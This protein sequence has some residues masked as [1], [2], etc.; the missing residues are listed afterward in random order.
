[1]KSILEEIVA[2]KRDEVEQLKVQLPLPQ[3]KDQ[4]SVPGK[5]L[6]SAALADDSEVKII[7]ELKKASPS[8]GVLVQD[9]NP[10]LLARQYRD[11][12]ASALSVLTEEK[13]FFGRPEYLALARRESELPVM[14]KDFF[15]D[16]YQIYHAASMGA[17][18]I[19][20]I[21]RLHPAQS[22]RTCLNTARQLGLDCLVEV[23]DE[24]ELD[25]A[26]QAGADIVGVNN[27]NLED[28]SVSLET[29]ERLGKRIPSDVI[30]VSESGILT[31]DDVRRL[32]EAG[33]NN[34][35]IGE[36]LVKSPDPVSLIRA[37]RES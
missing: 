6:F 12:G 34:F 22:L 13:Y 11:G 36:A 14:A 1:M 17:D 18:A 24:A 31:V 2:S 7:A 26:L 8:K 33:Y 25:I 23:H 4:L 29:S 10:A 28:F 37:L 16:R 19:L 32:R 20:L 3:L 27:R 5:H 30:R 15:I 21:A 9:F 35:L